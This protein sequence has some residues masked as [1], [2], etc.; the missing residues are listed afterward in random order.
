[1][2]LPCGGEYLTPIPEH[3]GLAIGDRITFRDGG[4]ANR[5]VGTIRELYHEQVPSVLTWKPEG[6]VFAEVDLNDG[7]EARCWFHRDRAERAGEL[8]GAL[9]APIE[10]GL[11]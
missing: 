6:L 7:S 10:G 1:M 5:L 4:R 8:D 11:F 9:G 2:M 3:E